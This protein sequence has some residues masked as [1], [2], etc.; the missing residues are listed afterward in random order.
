MKKTPYSA[1]RIGAALEFDTSQYS[2]SDIPFVEFLEYAVH[3]HRPPPSWLWETIG[4]H[5]VPIHLHPLDI[6]LAGDEDLQLWLES[7]K[8]IVRE[9]KCEAIVTD[10]GFWF[11]GPPESTWERAPHFGKAAEQCRERAEWIATAC[12]IPFRVENPP[13]D[14]MPDQ[15]SVWSFLES[16]SKGRGVEICLDLCHLH[17]YS[18]N[19][20][21]QKLTLPREFPWERVTEVH[22]GG[23]VAVDYMGHESMIDTHLAEI[24]PTQLEWL[25][26]IMEYRSGLRTDICL[27]MEPCAVTA[28]NA[29]AQSIT[30]RFQ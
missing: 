3:V 13:V 17:Q 2:E 11:L 24:D 16:V 9:F 30:A 29:T 6:N 27:E 5:R 20:C 23:C 18:V 8:P 12:G 1:M 4:K 26:A 14:W 28:F 19:V 22:L 21:R 25:R 15:P 10:L 7:F